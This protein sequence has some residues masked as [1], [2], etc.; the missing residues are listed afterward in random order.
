MLAVMLSFR[1][2]GHVSAT[3]LDFLIAWTPLVLLDWSI[4]GVL[5]G[6]ILWYWQKNDTWRATLMSGIMG[7]L[8]AFSIWVAIW[9]WQGM[10]RM[11]GLGE[12][13]SKAF[14]EVKEKMEISR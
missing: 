12:E 7:T 13:E 4:V 14:R 6:L 5:A 3:R 1:F 2:E 8:L 9:M 10:S 11:G